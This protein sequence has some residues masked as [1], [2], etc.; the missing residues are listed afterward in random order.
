MIYV[1]LTFSCIIDF[2]KWTE[3]LNGGKV[4]SREVPK[5]GLLGQIDIC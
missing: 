4:D 1:I 2:A 3:T 5:D